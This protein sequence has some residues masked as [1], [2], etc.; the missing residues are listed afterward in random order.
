MGAAGRFA[1][2]DIAALSTCAKGGFMPQAKHGGSGVCIVAVEG[3]KFDGTG[4]E[5]VHMGQIQVALLA[6][7]GSEGGR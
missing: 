7:V 5:N 1:A 4:F 2:L 3:S 6:V